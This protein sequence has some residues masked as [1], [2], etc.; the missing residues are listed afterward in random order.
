MHFF[1]CDLNTS[2]FFY[3]NAMLNF[4]VSKYNNGRL[5]ENKLILLICFLCLQIGIQKLLLSTRCWTSIRRKFQALKIYLY[6][7]ECFYV[8]FTENSH[9]I[10]IISIV[11]LTHS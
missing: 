1:P 3:M 6:T 4:K 9:G 8:I 2:K 5:L 10:G 7:L 11:G